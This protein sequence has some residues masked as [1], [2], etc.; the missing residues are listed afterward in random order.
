MLDVLHIDISPEVL[1]IGPGSASVVQPLSVD[2]S[3][4]SSIGWNGKSM[5]SAGVPARALPCGFRPEMGRSRA[6]R[7]RAPNDAR[8]SRVSEAQRWKRSRL[9][10]RRCPTNSGNLLRK[11]LN[12]S[13]FGRGGTLVP[14]QAA[15]FPMRLYRLR[16][17]SCFCLWEGAGGFSPL[18]KTHRINRALAPGLL[19]V[20]PT[21]HFPQPV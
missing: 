13:R 8:R 1:H 6:H 19:H 3:S 7:P 14:P 4:D 15:Y 12:K 9:Q 21:S 5:S 2:A 10:A 20:A 17:D 11:F 18:N 16:K